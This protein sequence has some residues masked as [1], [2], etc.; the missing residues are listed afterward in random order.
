MLSNDDRNQ[1]KEIAFSS[2]KNGIENGQALIVN[3]LDYSKALQEKRSTFVT[4]KIFHQLR[5]CIG[6]LEAHKPL[7][8]DVSENAYSAAF[9]DPRFP[10]LR[11]EELNNV[12]ISI[13]VL[14]I[15]EAIS[16]SSEKDLLNKI[17]VGIDGLTLEEGHHR[18]TFLPAVWE[19]VSSPEEFLNE[20]KQKASLPKDYWS[21]T[22]KISRYTT[23]SF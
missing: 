10:C 23:E 16:F 8:V 4:L 3:P 1:L 18:G 14:S 6:T 12:K 7:C 22:L 5:G 17:K 15:P 11:S 13:S 21:E 9:S 2:I 20:L 19:S